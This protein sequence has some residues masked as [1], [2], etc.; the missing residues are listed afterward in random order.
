MIIRGNSARN[1]AYAVGLA[2]FHTDQAEAIA[3]AQ[4]SLS[5]LHCGAGAI[6]LAVS[7][8]RHFQLP[9]DILRILANCLN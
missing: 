3:H 4:D 6:R 7:P 8:G 9:V 5:T 2:I 1:I